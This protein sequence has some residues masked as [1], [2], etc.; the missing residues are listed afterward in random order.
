MATINLDTWNGQDQTLP[1]AG[2]DDFQQLFPPTLFEE[3][4]FNFPDFSGTNN[5]STMHQPHGNVMDTHMGISNMS[6]NMLRSEMGPQSQIPPMT[7]ALI[8][9]TISSQR[10]PPHP[11]TRDPISEI[12]K[13]IQL[14]QQQRLHQQ[15]RQ[16][17]EQNMR[18]QKQFYA[19]Q[20]RSI[21]PPTPQSLEIQAATQFLEHQNQT[22]S[23]GMFDTYS[24]LK[25]TEILF[26]PLVSPAVTPLER[27]FPVDPS[28]SSSSPLFSPLSSP[29][30]HAQ[31]ESTSAVD[32]R[33]SGHISNSPMEM[34]MDCSPATIANVARM[35]RQRKATRP[36]KPSVR[37][38]PITKAQRRKNA[39]TP[40]NNAQLL[41]SGLAESAA[42]NVQHPPKP[43][44][45]SATSRDGS[46]DASVSPEALSGMP[47]PPR[48]SRRS[49]GQSPYI[50]PQ[51]NG[52]TGAATFMAPLAGN[53]PPATPS[54]LFRKSPKS[55]PADPSHPEQ[56]GSEYIESFEL[57]ESVDFPQPGLPS[58]DMRQPP[59][60][61]VEIATAKTA[62]FQPLPSPVLPKP[63]SASASTTKSHQLTPGSGTP[64]PKTT[65]LTTPRV[66]K[67]RPS[68][69][70]ISPALLPKIS[71]NIKPLLPGTP[72]MSAEDSAS[73]LLTSKSNYQNIVEGNEVPGV[74][75]PKEL[76]TNLTRKQTSHKIAEQG[77]RDRINS[78][79]QELETLLPKSAVKELG[80]V[81]GE[82]GSVQK[83]DR[84]Q[85][86][87][88]NSK[89]KTVELA[90]AYI[91]Q[92][93]EDVAVANGR[94]DEAEKKLGEKSAV[95]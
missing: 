77:R 8:H 72:G 43:K 86:N 80:G 79:I 45:D 60:P 18:L 90:I 11:T 7:S 55:K 40:V 56:S 25:E 6:T 39:S 44:S 19:Q 31:N 73:K 33:H 29:A 16:I 42:E 88:Q 4:E 26:T 66:P 75:Y 54:S 5:N 82:G 47:P 63:A 36:K 46:E 24:H 28:F 95:S 58:L 68:I 64:N 93:Q 59:Q 41:L 20:Q 81:E 34:D 85:L 48:P 13:Q 50:Q 70:S 83:K 52:N 61:P 65:S 94:A 17:A 67:K 51:N 14:L 23:S 71:P 2:D 10:M 32:Q 69:N 22:H 30:L 53:P 9:S 49:A 89:A 12:D 37:Q 84:K 78:A 38:S 91:K 76:S 3:L 87:S 57:P 15:S 62:S 92:L 74:S 21:V 1:S 27:H 35:A